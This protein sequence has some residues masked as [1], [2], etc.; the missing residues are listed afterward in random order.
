[1][2]YWNGSLLSLRAM[3]LGQR[4]RHGL[5]RRCLSTKHMRAERTR[6]YRRVWREAAESL[7]ADVHNWAKETLAIRLDGR[8]TY[9]DCNCT[10]I[11]GPAT[12]QRAGNKPLVAKRLAEDDLPVPAWRQFSLSSVADALD[13]MRAGR[14]YVVKP[15]CDTGAGHGVTTHVRSRSD[16]FRAAARAAVF[17][18][19][20]SIEEQVEGG[21]YRLLYLDGILLDAV[22]REPP[23]VT[24]DGRS[25]IRALVERANQM[26]LA[27]GA[28]AA[29]TLLSCDLEMQQTLARQG[30]TPAWVLRAGQI[31]RLKSVVND[32]SAAEN[33]PASHL[34]CHAVI[35]AGA[36]A[37]AAIGV[38]LA[39]IDVIT[40]DPSRPLE[41]V[42][43]VILE[44]NTTPGLY[45]H[46]HRTGEPKR[47][48]VDILSH[49]LGRTD[50]VCSV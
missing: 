39:G 36:R 17:G 37:A 40:P 9:V 23:T 24:G 20:L 34:L 50:H 11:D 8:A 45:Y 47:V 29:Q 32:N 13:F 38:K 46:Y 26:R 18:R 27:S 48:A 16:L 15:A 30:L 31:V 41:E 3:A 42:G 19:D 10:S 33:F 28:A 7:G 6:F 1:M 49:L 25:T 14:D 43:G 35:D 5:R 4:L 44:V 22:L 2:S 21:N 12:L